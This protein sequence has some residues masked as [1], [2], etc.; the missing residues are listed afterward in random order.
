MDCTHKFLVI[1]KCWLPFIYYKLLQCLD[2]LLILHNFS[3]QMCSLVFRLL[4]DW[5]LDLNPVS[6]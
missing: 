5:F 1:S 6:N 2:L 3:V 4:G